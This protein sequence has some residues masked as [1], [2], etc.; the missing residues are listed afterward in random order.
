MSEKIPM[1]EELVDTKVGKVGWFGGKGNDLVRFVYWDGRF[2]FLK[3]AVL[4]VLNQGSH[5][6]HAFFEGQ[7]FYRMDDG[8]WVSFRYP[9]HF[10]RLIASYWALKGSDILIDIVKEIDVEGR[11]I[12]VE[13]PSIEELYDE[14][15]K[16][17]DAKRIPV[18]TKI[19]AKDKGFARKIYEKIR[20]KIDCVILEDRIIKI[21]LVM[22]ADGRSYDVADLMDLTKQLFAINNLEQLDANSFYYRPYATI[23]N[24]MLKLSTLEKPVTFGLFP[25]AWGPYL[26]TG[27]VNMVVVPWRR[28]TDE[29]FKTYAKLAGHYTNSVLSTNL[30][31]V[32]GFS[33]GI[34]LTPDGYVGE[35][36]AMNIFIVKNGVVYTPPLSEGI[37]PGITRDSVIKLLRYKQYEVVEKRLSLD[38]LLSAD[39]VFLTGTAAEVMPLNSV[40]IPDFEKMKSYDSIFSPTG[41]KMKIEPLEFRKVSFNNPKIANEARKVFFDLFNPRTDVNK[42]FG[43]WLQEMP[44]D[45]KEKIQMMKKARNI[46]KEEVRAEIEKRMKR[47]QEAKVF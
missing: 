8:R 41:E 47:C 20:E 26:G 15:A 19:D 36:S 37:L 13:T 5:Y 21:L 43:S 38:E 32:F 1:V 17:Y 34:M 46:A 2:V 30:A 9:E 23:S 42:E 3:D 35:G 10:T 7:R 33:E 28:I 11:G 18:Y 16:C 40:S 39:E 6:S 4:P 12:E 22:Y 24:S 45:S 27:E 25:L 14:A 44:S 29:Q 31:K